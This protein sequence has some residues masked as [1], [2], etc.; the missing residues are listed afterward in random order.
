MNGGFKCYGDMFEFE[1]HEMRNASEYTRRPW[2]EC[3]L[4]GC[5]FECES[6]EAEFTPDVG[7][8]GE[9]SAFLCPAC[10]A[11]KARAGSGRRSP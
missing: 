9:G 1:L 10:M 6:C 4:T 3:W 11:A 2:F 5:S 8:A 7:T